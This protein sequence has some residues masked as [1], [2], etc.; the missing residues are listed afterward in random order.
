MEVFTPLVLSGKVCLLRKMWVCFNF[1]LSKIE[2]KLPRSKLNFVVIKFKFYLKK[3]QILLSWNLLPSLVSSN[4]HKMSGIEL[5]NLN[6]VI[7][8]IGEWENFEFYRKNSREFWMFHTFVSTGVSCL[9]T[10][11]IYTGIIFIHCPFIGDKLLLK[12][13]PNKHQRLVMI[14]GIYQV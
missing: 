12:C 10:S 6:W 5:L 4:C 9:Y 3:N 1:Y 11:Y 7:I 2:L 8:E 13:S 14:S